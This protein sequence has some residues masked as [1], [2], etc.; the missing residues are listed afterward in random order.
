MTSLDDFLW[1]YQTLIHALG[2]NSLLALSMY[3]VLSVGQ[4]AMGQ[5]A[6]MGLGAYTAA[7][8]TLRLGLPFP[9]VL[10]I[11]ALVPAV[12]ALVIATPTLRLTGVYLA[13][14]TIG[15]GEVLRVAYVNSDLLGGAMGINGIPQKTEAWHVFSL[16]GLAMLVLFLLNRSRHGRAMEAI[17]A[18]ETAAS[19]MGI[20]CPAY[21]MAALLASAV[22]AGLA[23]GLS[24][25]A[26]SFIGPAEFSFELSVTVLSFALLGGIGSPL[27]PVL[28]AML[29]TL[30]PE[31]LRPLSDFRLVINGLIIVIV[32][33]YLPRGILPWRMG[34]VP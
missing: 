29:L 9:L 17:R 13:I 16:L 22:L 21:K 5:V 7:L 14:S 12:I 26:A 2:I 30:L 11:A 32:V 23:G 34:R 6:F 3:V 1:A 27:G 15:L 19:V 28:G 24:A 4:L 10:L 31:V 8:L 18:D 20:N 25:H 33:M